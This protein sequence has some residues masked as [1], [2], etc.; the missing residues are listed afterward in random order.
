MTPR[1]INKVGAQLERHK[2]K[3]AKERDQLR[4]LRHDIEAVEDTASEAIDHLERAI[5]ALSQ[6]V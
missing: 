4:E 1:E 5:E 6:Y 3:I 2:A